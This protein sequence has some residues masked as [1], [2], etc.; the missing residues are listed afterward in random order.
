M[1]YDAAIYSALVES[2]PLSHVYWAQSQ[3][4]SAAEL[5][6]A[7]IIIMIEREGRPRYCFD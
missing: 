4:G 6:L 2:P 1:R 7:I 3:M 5:P